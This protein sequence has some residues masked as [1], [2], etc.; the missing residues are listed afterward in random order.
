MKNS[1]LTTFNLVTLE[2]NTFNL[3]LESMFITPE[4]MIGE[5]IPNLIESGE[6]KN[7]TTKTV[8]WDYIKNGVQQF[9]CEDEAIN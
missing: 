8:Y 3:E 6:L 7:F 5:L 9:N 4:M 1:T 2:Y